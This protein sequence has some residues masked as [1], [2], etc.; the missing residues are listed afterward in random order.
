[1]AAAMSEPAIA[2]PLTVITDD[3]RRWVVIGICLNKLLTPV[4]RTVLG[5]QIPVWY[6]NL[7]HPPTNIAKQ[8]YR[9]Q[10]KQIPPSTVKLNYS[11]INKNYDN[12]KATYSAYDYNVKDPESLAKLF[13]QPFMVKFTGFDQTMD[14]SAAL[15]LIYTETD[16]FHSSGAAA[17][18]KIV[19]SMVRNEWAHCDFSH[20]SEI[21]YNICVQHIESF[22]RKLN[23]SSADENDFVNELN[24]WKDKGVQLCC[25]QAIDADLLN[26]VKT[27]VAQLYDSVKVW[28]E[29]SD[30]AQLRIMES[31][32]SFKQFFN[33]ELQTTRENQ[34]VM[35]KD[36]ENLKK[37]VAK[38][39]IKNPVD[40]RP[41]F[42]LPDRANW[43][44]GRKS[45]LN[46][47]H[48]LFQTGHDINTLRVSIASVCGLGGSG[49]TSLAA[50]YA[51]RQKDGFLAKMKKSLPTQ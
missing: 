50:E 17:Q 31:L 19:R 3:Q 8:V 10:V 16:P 15:T 37:Q 9:A 6:N 36:I 14:L 22:V 21:N 30:E 11:N 1:M 48:T 44:S 42:M 28:R 4:L 38:L 46:S 35:E 13:V 45:E 20:W 12:H 7:C 43:F 2:T 5:Q 24:N 27:E 47:L 41:L 40:V 33:Q 23:L 39:A 51:H 32:Q 25:G 18:A 49:K 26:L 34:S 29:E